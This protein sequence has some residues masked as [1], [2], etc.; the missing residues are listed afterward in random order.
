MLDKEESAKVITKKFEITDDL[1]FIS[2]LFDGSE[3]KQICSV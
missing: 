3:G 1:R 2:F